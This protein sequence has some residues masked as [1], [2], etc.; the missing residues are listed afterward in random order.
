MKCAE[1]RVTPE[2]S[3]E[4]VQSIIQSMGGD[5]MEF[6]CGKYD[7]IPACRS[8]YPQMMQAF[9]GISLRVANGTMKPKAGSP[10]G[11]LLQLFIDSQQTND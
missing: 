10:V 3:I 2:K 8:G 6:M 5:M 4:Y 11:P 1:R 7:S 9:Q